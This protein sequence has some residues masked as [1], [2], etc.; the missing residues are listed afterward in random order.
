MTVFV[1]PVLA[2]V[3]GTKCRGPDGLDNRC[4]SVTVLEAE[5]LRLGASTVGLR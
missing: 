3:A 5:G 2:G 4:L 1:V